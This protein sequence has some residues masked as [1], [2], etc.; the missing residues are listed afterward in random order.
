MSAQILQ[1]KKMY[2]VFCDAS[3]LRK[4]ILGYISGFCQKTSCGEMKLFLFEEKKKA[5]TDRGR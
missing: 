2:K 4:K 1:K 3:T 5:F